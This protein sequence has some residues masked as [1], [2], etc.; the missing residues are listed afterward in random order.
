MMSLALALAVSWLAF[1]DAAVANPC[2][3]DDERPAESPL[4][5]DAA[6]YRR[7]ADLERRDGHFRAARIAYRQALRCDPTDR[8]ARAGLF[9]LCAL[10]G[11]G[12]GGLPRPDGDDD[13]GDAG[14]SGPAD[15]RLAGTDPDLAAAVALMNRGDRAQ[16]LHDFEAMRGEG[17]DR[18][19]ALALL[20]GICAYEL[21]DDSLARR[22]LE[23]ARAE[24]RIAPTTMFF[25]GLIALREGDGPLATTLLATAGA[26]E[27][28]LA[29]LASPLIRMAR[30]EGKIVT[31]AMVEVGYDS[32]VE[33]APDGS[34]LGGGAGDAHGDGLLALFLRPLDGREAY[35]RFAAQYRKQQ[36]L[37]SFDLGDVSGAAGM[38]HRAGANAFSAEYA[39]DWLALGGAPYLSAHRLIGAVRSAHDRWTLGARYSARLASFTGATAAPYSGIRQDAQVLGEVNAG[40]A[41]SVGAGYRGA[42]DDTRRAVLGYHEHGPTVT[43][44]FTL[45][46]AYR[47]LVEA[48]VT[49]RRY[50][51]P[52]PDL[53]V[54]R[55]DR[56][57]DAG[58]G[59]ETDL[60][61]RWTLRLAMT[62][63]RARSNVAE[64][65]YARTTIALGLIYTAGVR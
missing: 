38:R 33:L 21:G 2:Q 47:L 28:S 16:A 51:T 4:R 17:S 49:W 36:R 8:V 27:D 1:G 32:N 37:S 26:R 6:V 25:L 31:T 20:A 53:L 45:A 11:G 43:L 62:A 52:D 3:E 23:E 59:A 29:R 48:A 41:V 56:Y 24:P 63:R 18:D 40:P 57:L 60:A 39:Y 19:P 54:E 46:E 65:S 34:L 12:A 61:E 7:V 58:L 22:R 50:P 14:W 10:A 13:A 30:R 15:P 35:L 64:L 44:R 5:Q 42:W 55:A 9:E